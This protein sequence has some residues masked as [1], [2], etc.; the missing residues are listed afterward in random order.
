MVGQKC[1]IP[2]FSQRNFNNAKYGVKYILKKISG[3][4]WKDKQCNGQ[5]KKD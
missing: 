1:K 5:K 3:R 4:K 2:G